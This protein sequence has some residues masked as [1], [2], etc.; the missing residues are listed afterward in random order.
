MRW[1]VALWNPFAKPWMAPLVISSEWCEWIFCIMFWTHGAGEVGTFCGF[2]YISPLYWF[3]NWA[4]LFGPN[5]SLFIYF[6]IKATMIRFP[7]LF[8]L[9]W[10][11]VVRCLWSVF[12]KPHLGEYL[13]GLWRRFGSWFLWEQCFGGSIVGWFPSASK[14]LNLEC[15]GNS[16]KEQLAK[17][18]AFNEF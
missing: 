16:V 10:G 12:Q 15:P 5:H 6:F 1:G 13:I 14:E 17:S 8:F 18:R 4:R 11:P 3:M 9:F 2:I 7:V